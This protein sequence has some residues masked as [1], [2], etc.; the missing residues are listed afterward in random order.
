MLFRVIRLRGGIGNQLFILCEVIKRLK[1]GERIYVDENTGFVKDKYRRS[2]ILEHLDIKFT[3]APMILCYCL[4]AIDRFVLNFVNRSIYLNDYF[5]FQIADDVVERVMAVLNIKQYNNDLA[6]NCALLHFRD[7]KGLSED[8]SNLQ[9]EYYA[10]AIEC[11][12]QKGITSFHVAGENDAILT[13][14]ELQALVGD[15]TIRLLDFN[16]YSDFEE[17][18]Y[19]SNYKDIAISNSTYAWWIARFS[20]MKNSRVTIYMPSKKHLPISHA[21]NVNELCHPDWNVL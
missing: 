17:L 6:G 7:Y 16:G 10:K 3:R 5:Q 18:L 19:L 12:K 4:L 9:N 8:H 13:E 2:S 14:E 11:L 1:L 20:T 21:W 15:C